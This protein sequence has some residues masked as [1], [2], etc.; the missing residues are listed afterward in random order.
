MDYEEQTRRLVEGLRAWVEREGARLAGTGERP[1]QVFLR[2][3]RVLEYVGE[4]DFGEAVRELAALG[5][6]E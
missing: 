5:K 4:P 6:R 1:S 2:R 3:R